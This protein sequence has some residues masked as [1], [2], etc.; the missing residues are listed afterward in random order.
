MRT[1]TAPSLTGGGNDHAENDIGEDT[2]FTLQLCLVGSSG[3]VC[4]KQYEVHT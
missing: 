3:E 1:R 4:S 2:K